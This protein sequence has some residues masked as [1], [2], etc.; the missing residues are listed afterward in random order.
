MEMNKNTESVKWLGRGPGESYCDKKQAAR[1][2]V[3]ESNI[4]KM[5]S[6]YE[7]PQENGNRTAWHSRDSQFWEAG[8]RKGF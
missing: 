4:D 1:I 3:W 2:G 7:F 8:R 5:A 6:N